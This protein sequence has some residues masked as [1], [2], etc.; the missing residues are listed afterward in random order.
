MY[1]G[2]MGAGVFILY[3]LSVNP[4]AEVTYDLC[5]WQEPN[6]ALLNH[7]NCAK[8]GKKC[9]NINQCQFKY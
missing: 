9:L 8:N 3:P 2:H 5:T 4:R 6:L 1:V 7:K